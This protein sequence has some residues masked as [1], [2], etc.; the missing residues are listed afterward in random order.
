[1]RIRSIAGWTL[2]ALIVLVSSAVPVWA[3]T[4]PMLVPAGPEDPT[5]VLV[6]LGGAGVAWQ[7][8]RSRVRK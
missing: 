8:F 3:F 1:M 4:R 5:M 6:A 2:A 7:Y